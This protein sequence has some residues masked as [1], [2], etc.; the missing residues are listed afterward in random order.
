VGRVSKV[1]LSRVVWWP[2]AI[3]IIMMCVL[4]LQ[5]VPVAQCRPSICALSGPCWLQGRVSLCM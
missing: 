2:A 4:G 1:L 3:I 5:L